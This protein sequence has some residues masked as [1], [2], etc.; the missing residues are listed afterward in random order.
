[1]PNSR[2]PA[3]PGVAWSPNRQP[4]EVRLHCWLQPSGSSDAF[5]ASTTGKGTSFPGSYP[6]STGKIMLVL[7]RGSGSPGGLRPRAQPQWQG[8]GRCRQP[9]CPTWLWLLQQAP[10][11]PLCRRGPICAALS[12]GAL[13]FFSLKHSSKTPVG[14][15]QARKWLE[16][17]PG[18]TT[19]P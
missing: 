4:T 6:D 15:L 12:L 14:I 5:P 17:P 16:R 10:P 7:G 3:L 8:A 9:C 2:R 1:M 11:P 18:T 13:D 19:W